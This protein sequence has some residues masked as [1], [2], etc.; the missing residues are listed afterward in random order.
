MTLSRSSAFERGMQGLIIRNESGLM[1]PM[2]FSDSQ[3]HMW[4]YVAPQLDSHGRLWYIVLKGR[5]V[6]ATTFFQALTF[7]LTIERANVQSLIIAQDLDSATDIFAKAKTFYD[8]L[9][10]PK[11]KPSKVKELQFELPGGVSR[12][13]V[14]SAGIASKGRG[15][16]QTCVHCSE[17]AFWQHPEVLTGLFQAMPD[18]GDTLWVLESTANGIAGQG[19]LFYDQWK[20]AISGRSKLTPIFIPWFL[21]PKYRESPALPE[22]EWDEEE[23]LLVEA[24]GELGLDGRS[25]RWRRNTIETKLSGLLEM[26][27]QEYPSTPEEAF[28][29]SGLPAFDPMGIL[30]QQPNISPAKTRMTLN[31]AGKFESNRNGELFIWKEPIPGHQYAIGVD[32]SEGHKGGDYTC[33]QVLDMDDLEQVAVIHGLVQPYDFSRMLN[34][35]GRWY[36]TAIVNIECK[37]TGWAV[38]DYMMRVFNYPRFHPWKGK[39]DHYPNGQTRLWG[40]DTNVYSRPLLIEAGRRALNKA[41]CRIRD[42]ATLDEI[43]LFSR[44]DNGKYEAETGH[45]DRVLALLLALRS[46]EENYS[47]IRAS[48]LSTPEIS[49]PDQMGVRIIEAHDA[50]AAAMR[51][52]HQT[53]KKRSRA[54]VK[55]WMAL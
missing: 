16:T 53:L 49:A 39:S 42:A 14:V 28:I 55:N 11:M 6:Y 50:S 17:V 30:R 37:S 29:S 3:K 10:L 54:A 41:L 32:T 13:K 38:Q 20:A 44:Q 8:H 27:H 46:R 12:F 18:L 23:K 2:G 48:V 1:V 43:K 4:K 19:Q 45:D 52:I 47:P 21:M 31:S 35:L 22:N 26:F 33:A 34:V 51:R 7:L 15:T 36:N 5:Q 9:P 40:W 24:F 25:L